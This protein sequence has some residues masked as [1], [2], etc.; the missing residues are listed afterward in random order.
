MS[1]VYR[2]RV[3][4][5]MQRVRRVLRDIL[6]ERRLALRLPAPTIFASLHSTRVRQRRCGSGGE[7]VGRRMHP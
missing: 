5:R 7:A 2:I 4:H 3:C 1:R 6:R